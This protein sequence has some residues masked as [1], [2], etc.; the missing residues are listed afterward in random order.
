MPF[1]NAFL[2]F[3]PTAPYP[4]SPMNSHILSSK[5]KLSAQMTGLFLKIC[6]LDGSGAGVEINHGVALLLFVVWRGWLVELSVLGKGALVA[7]ASVGF[8]VRLELVRGAGGLMIR[9]LMDSMR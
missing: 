3:V 4:F 8:V 5:K 2:A 9:E 7:V 6:F 1:G